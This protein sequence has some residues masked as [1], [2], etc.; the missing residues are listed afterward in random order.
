MFTIFNVESVLC[1]LK[2][3]IKEVNKLFLNGNELTVRLRVN[4][5]IYSSFDGTYISY[6]NHSRMIIS[7][8]DLA[9]R[10]IDR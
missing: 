5:V 2:L 8:Y 10:S 1:V 4:S 6:S 7:M 3:K 9:T